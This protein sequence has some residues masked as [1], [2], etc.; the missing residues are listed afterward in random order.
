MA[1]EQTIVSQLSQ[2]AERG[3]RPER[4]QAA[5][6][7]VPGLPETLAALEQQLSDA[8]LDAEARLQAAARH[9]VSAG[10][11]RIRPMVTLLACGANGG[12]MKAA[13][14][15]AVAAEL[16]HSATLLHDD[17]IDDGPVRRDLLVEA[18]LPLRPLTAAP[19]K[20]ARL[21]APLVRAVLAAWR[22]AAA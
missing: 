15:Y 2:T 21:A 1:S 12:A 22:E 18:W 11:K 8:T 16:T 13:I 10:G 3:V 4:A 14:P 6:A 7:E 9:L 20:V 5:L 17:V 19:A